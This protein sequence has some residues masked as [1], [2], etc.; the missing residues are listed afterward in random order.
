M[1]IIIPKYSG[2]CYGVKLAVNAAYEMISNAATDEQV[3]MLGEVVHNPGVVSDLK[4]LDMRL[5]HAISEIPPGE[6][7]KIL[8]RAHGVA[9]AVS[10]EINKRGFTA[11]DMTCSHVK[12]IHAFVAYAAKGGLDVIVCG[13]PGHPEVEGIISRIN[14][15]VIL[16]KNE[17]EARALITA[18]T[19]FS[20]KGVCLVAQTTFS[21][22]TYRDIHAYL[23]HECPFLPRL[24]AHDTI[25]A[26]TAHRQ[27]E[28]RELAE[29][30]NPAAIII[31]GGKNSANVNKLYDIACEYC[32]NTQFVENIQQLAPIKV[33]EKDT[34]IV[35]GGASTPAGAVQKIVDAIKGEGKSS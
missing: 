23:T 12:K 1:K 15:R 26:A 16:I 34:V 30:E 21:V 5:I 18:E 8:I 32:K 2:F 33:N 28:L 13:N 14:T 29:K 10:D 19:A 27:N 22:K 24:T 6:K 7:A 31:V 20:E 17:A 3:Y 11:F 35:C 9:A 25:C 4:A